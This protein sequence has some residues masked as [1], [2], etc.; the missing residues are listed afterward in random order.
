MFEG[1]LG[2]LSL[3]K[4]EEEE[5]LTCSRKL[6]NILI[7]SRALW[8]ILEILYF[9]CVPFIPKDIPGNPLLVW[10]NDDRDK[11]DSDLLAQLGH[12]S[13]K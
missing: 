9:I 13:S 11:L 4:I 2:S 12:L 10:C 1:Q 5:K 7:L 3:V 8:H 6:Q